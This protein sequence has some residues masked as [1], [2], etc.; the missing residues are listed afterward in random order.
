L[1]SNLTRQQRSYSLPTHLCDFELEKNIFL[2]KP[3]KQERGEMVDTERRWW[4]DTERGEMVDTEKRWKAAENIHRGRSSSPKD[5]GELIERRK[6]QRDLREFSM[7]RV[8]VSLV[9]KKRKAGRGDSLATERLSCKSIKENASWQRKKGKR[10][11]EVR[12][13]SDL[14][15]STISKK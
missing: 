2:L 11:K 13:I 6:K 8:C 10:R 14:M 4:V 1:S 3:R 12:H 9:M 7:T 15:L 5:I